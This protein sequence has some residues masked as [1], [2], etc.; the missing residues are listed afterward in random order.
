MFSHKQ[1]ND[2][3]HNTDYFICLQR[4][5]SG[6]MSRLG[7]YACDHHNI[8]RKYIKSE[9]SSKKQFNMPHHSCNVKQWAKMK[10]T[11]FLYRSHF[12]CQ[13]DFSDLIKA[14]NALSEKCH[15][16]RIFSSYLTK[17]KRKWEVATIKSTLSHTFDK[18]LQC[19]YFFLPICGPSSE[20]VGISKRYFQ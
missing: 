7:S 6:E 4:V 19:I 9:I 13:L 5:A 10:L 12:W 8:F 20:E 14:Q 3:I 15:L 2:I 18:L 17:W 11:F 16:Q 1:A